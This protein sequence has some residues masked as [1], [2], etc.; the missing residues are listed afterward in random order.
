MWTMQARL[1]RICLWLLLGASCQAQISPGPLSRAHQSLEGPTQ[2]TTCHRLGGGQATFKCL[3][4]HAEIAERLATH[5][6]LHAGYGLVVGSS[7][8]CARC[9]SEHNG[10]EFALIKWDLRTFDH[11]QT[12]YVLEG[13]HAGLT[14]NRCHTAGHITP[15]AKGTIKI[16]DLNQSFL[17]V[18]AA[19]TTCHQDRHEGRL[20]QNC[21]QCHNYTDWRS[22]STQFDHS[23]TRYPLTGL[24]TQVACAKCHTA[25]ADAKPRYFGVA[26]GTC[27]DCHQDPHSGTFAQ[28]SCQSCHNTSNWKRVA[29]ATLELKF[30]HSKTRYPLLGK[31]QE[32]DCLQCHHN[33]DFK[34]PLVFGKCMDCHQDEH[35]GQFTKRADQGECSSCHNVNG[36]KPALFGVK[37]HAATGYPLQA[38]HAAVQCAQCHVPR[39]KDTIYKLKFDRCL[40][41]HKDEHQAQFAS[42]PYVNRCEQCHTLEGFKPSTFGLARH[43]QA[44]F[45]LTNA[46]VAITCGE[47][48][49]PMESA[50]VKNTAVY[51]FNDMSCT[52]CHEDPHRGQFRDRMAKILNGSAAGCEACHTTKTWKDVS[53]FDHAQTSFALLGAHRGVACIDCHKSA[54]LE[55]TLIHV[56]FHAAPAKCEQCHA[57]IHGKQFARNGVTDCASC[58]NS[59]RWKPSTFDHNTRT[60]FSLEGAH[61]NVRCNDC[62]KLTEMVEGKPV[63]FYKPTPKECSACHG[64]AVPKTKIGT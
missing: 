2:C 56:D 7:Q 11:K 40:E 36:F 61:R 31:H 6:G 58:H 54:N 18:S 39:G 3:D 37:E 32:V 42:A 55:T 51:R 57:E 63:L 41:C 59:T 24:H 45:I 48:H 60:A 27:S 8:G 23:K 10:R 20:G 43:K 9:H 15:A 64:A 33:G 46:H 14:C 16:K 47:C 34:K 22:V 17:G 26:F 52:A 62:H 38:K 44:R 4:C 35:R 30:D 19:C 5:K 25:G 13:K 28:Q 50:Q 12:G 29:T 21:L 53:R 1:I 49:K